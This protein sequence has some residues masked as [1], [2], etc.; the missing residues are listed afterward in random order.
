MKTPHIIITGGRDFEGTK[1]D[2]EWLAEFIASKAPCVVHHGAA[3]G[4][5]TWAENV[6]KRISGVTVRRHRAD[7]NKY[8]KAAGPIRNSDM[9]AAAWAANRQP[10]IGIA[11]PGGRGTASMVQILRIGGSVLIEPYRSRKY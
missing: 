5:D 1:A 11:W 8:G 4:A 9:Y 10:P 6:A 2:E 7:W 3:T